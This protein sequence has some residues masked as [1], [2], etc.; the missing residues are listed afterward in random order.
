MDWFGRTVELKEVED[1]IGQDVEWTGEQGSVMGFRGKED[2]Q[3]LTIQKKKRDR[4]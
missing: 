2:R 1:E 3:D 4:K